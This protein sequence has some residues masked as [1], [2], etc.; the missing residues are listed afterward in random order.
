MKSSASEKESADFWRSH[1]KLAR[2]L[3]T[4]R[5]HL[6]GVAPERSDPPGVTSWIALHVIYDEED[7]LSGQSCDLDLPENEANQHSLQLFLC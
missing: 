2:G 6:Q 3:E 4:R 5:Q 7:T 1:V